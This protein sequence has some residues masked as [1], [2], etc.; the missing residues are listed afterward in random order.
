MVK[1]YQTNREEELFL[2]HSKREAVATVLII[3]ELALAARQS[4]KNK[5]ENQPS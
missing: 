3:E 1:N 4:N 2:Q 5:I